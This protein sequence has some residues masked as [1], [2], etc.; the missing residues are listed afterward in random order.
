LQIIAEFGGE[1]G[2]GDDAEIDE[3]ATG[4]LDWVSIRHAIII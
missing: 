1:L 2:V 3:L 4:V